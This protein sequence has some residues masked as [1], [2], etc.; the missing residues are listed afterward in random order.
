LAAPLRV[1]PKPALNRIKKQRPR[2]EARAA[3]QQERTVQ[4]KLQR[5]SDKQ[6]K[7][8]LNH[9][10]VLSDI[11]AAQREHTQKLEDTKK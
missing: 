7:G 2:D 1:G 11:Q 10:R 5:F 8:D 4:E 9:R 6:N 3:Q